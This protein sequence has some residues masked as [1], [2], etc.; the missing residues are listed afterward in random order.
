MVREAPPSG[1]RPGIRNRCLRNHRRL[2][3]PLRTSQEAHTAH[4]YGP[5]TPA[6]GREEPS[7][8]CRRQANPT[9]SVWAV[10]V[11]SHGERA[12]GHEGGTQGYVK[13]LEVS[14]GT[15]TAL[16]ADVFGRALLSSGQAAALGSVRA[17][18]GAAHRAPGPRR[19]A[20][21]LAGPAAPAS[22]PRLSPHGGTGPLVRRDGRRC[23]GG[24]PRL[25]RRRAEMPAPGRLDRLGPGAPVATAAV[26]RQ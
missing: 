16:P 13:V 17:A 2:Q 1:V 26:R 15:A 14:V 23:V 3:R 10:D 11:P 5:D 8:S 12:L 19:G 20:G 21:A 18:A 7:I 24:A 22:L 4:Y 6:T 9:Y 25:G